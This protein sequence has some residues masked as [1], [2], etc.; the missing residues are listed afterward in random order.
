[1]STGQFEKTCVKIVQVLCCIAWILLFSS[2]ALGIEKYLSTPE[3]PWTP[4]V[5]HPDHA[6]GPILDSTQ[7]GAWAD[8]NT[9]GGVTPSAGDVVVIHHD[10][11]FATTADVSDVVIETT[12]SLRFAPDVDTSLRVVTLQVIEGATLEIGTMSTPIAP[13]VTAEIIFADR[14][15]DLTIDPGQYSNGLLVYGTV[16][17]HGT[18]LSESFARLAQE[19]LAGDTGLVLSTPVT[20]WQVGDRVLIPDT[21]NTDPRPSK[22]F[23]SQTEQVVIESISPDGQTLGISPMMHTHSGARDA[24]GVLT[25]L[26]HA[27][28]LDRNIILRSENPAGVRGHTITCANANVDIRYVLFKDLGRTTAFPI[29]NTTFNPDGTVAVIGT[30][31]AARLPLHTH[32]LDGPAV[33]PTN[34]YQFTLLGNVVDGGT[35]LHAFYWGI[36][37]H[38][39][40]YGLIQDNIVLNYSGANIATHDGNESFNLF[41]HNFAVQTRAFG[42]LGT[43]DRGRAGTNFWFRGQQNYLRNN[44]AADHNQSGY[45]INAYRLGEYDTY[46]PVAPGSATETLVNMN[47][48]P[49]LEFNNNESYGPAFYGLDLWDIGSTGEQLW[50]VAPSIIKDFKLWHHR[51]IG[52]IFY[53]S[54]R[55]IMDGMTIRG[56]IPDLASRYH[57]PVGIDLRNQYRERGF[58]IR[59]SD[60]QGMRDGIRVDL[61]VI[62]NDLG[63][64]FIF[65]VPAPQD[66]PGV[67]QIEDSY[68]RNYR[69]ISIVTRRKGRDIGSPRETVIDNVMFGPVDV[70]G[71]PASGPQQTIAMNYL[72]RTKAQVIAPDDVTVF[73][74]N[75]IPGNDFEVF[76]LEQAPDFIVPQTSDDGFTVGSPEAGLTNQ[77]NWDTYGIAIAGRLA[78]CADATTRPEVLGFTCQ[79]G[80]PN[81]EPDPTADLTPPDTPANVIQTLVT[82]D[83]VDLSWDPSADDVAVL[84]YYISSNGVRVGDVTTTVFSHTAL[85]P[86]TAY[87]YT[88]AAYDE[89]GNISP[90]SVALAVTTQPAMATVTLL[91]LDQSGQPISQGKVRILELGTYN[92]GSTVELFVGPTYSI[93][94]ERDSAKGTY[95]TV[96]IEASATTIAVPFWT[97]DSTARDQN[98]GAVANGQLEILGRPTFTPTGTESYPLGSRVYIRGKIGNAKGR[99]HQITFNTGLTEIGSRFWTVD[100]TPR[101]QNGQTVTNAQLEILG[102]PVFTPGETFSYPLGAKPYIRGRMGNVKGSWSRVTFNTG[103]TAIGSRFWTVDST[104]RDESGTVVENAQL[105]IYPA[106]PFTPAET[107]TYPLGAKPYI[108]GLV[109]GTK[110][111]WERVTFNTGLTDIGSRF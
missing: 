96:T 9:W 86:N 12:G 51:E 91:A 46:V 38:D 72:F 10:V 73:D 88:V 55:I 89:A 61:T 35:D 47:T 13:D 24:D 39:S 85:E 37:I 16:T 1:M 100:S 103:L 84:G 107:F 66:R 32:H 81:P 36:T 83:Q 101:D 22:G 52:T 90:E 64:D 43:E 44:V 19:P 58:V 11:S 99:W 62:P 4:N 92:S 98:S 75:G 21:R 104:P 6:Q 29:D 69:D 30:N 105:E 25:F 15:I 40:H 34:G 53:R 27:G 26:P 56:T 8:S 63:N 108:R 5:A 3:D 2:P 79:I 68:L 18:P 80:L 102:M 95:Q 17:M 71:H 59:N 60:I 42:A 41:D 45:S 70:V 31:Q 28:N 48:L 23:V 14:P 33:T 7:A 82:T 74:Y 67:I 50:D 106:P 57:N 109:G 20:G 65:D 93:R 94:G 110:G 49:I 54:H 78:P 77:E 97:A 76:Y 111:S 87:T